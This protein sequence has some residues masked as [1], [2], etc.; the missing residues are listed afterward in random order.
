MKSIYDRVAPTGEFNYKSARVPVP[1]GLNVDAWKRYLED[2]RDPNLVQFLEFGWPIN[3]DRHSPL[4]PTF[5]NHASAR[6]FP[7]H[8]KHYIQKELGYGALLGPFKGPPVVYTHI[9]PLMTQPKKDAEFIQVIMDLSWPDGASVKGQMHHHD[10]LG[11]K[12]AYTCHLSNKT[13]R[14]SVLLSSPQIWLMKVSK[15]LA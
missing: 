6:N 8:I 15:K 4:V 5:E 13:T 1:S 9:S 11:S 12:C 2:Y 3:F 10:D 14:K 7:Q